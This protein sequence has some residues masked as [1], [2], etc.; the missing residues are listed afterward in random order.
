MSSLP[1][2]YPSRQFALDWFGNC[3]SLIYCHIKFTGYSMGKALSV[4][5]MKMCHSICHYA[6]KLSEETCAYTIQ[7]EMVVSRDYFLHASLYCEKV[8]TA[9]RVPCLRTEP[10]FWRDEWL[11]KIPYSIPWFQKVQNL[12]LSTHKESKTITF[13][14]YINYLKECPLSPPHILQ[15]TL[16]VNIW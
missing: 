12:I 1:S 11:K 10:L 2:P 16:L 9:R 14:A 8:A 4:F 3:I 5:S 6:Q 15:D 13:W 7:N